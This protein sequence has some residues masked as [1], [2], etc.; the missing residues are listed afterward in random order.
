MS[1]IKYT[2][3]V[4]D[5]KYFRE[6][7]ALSDE[8]ILPQEQIDGND[9][10]EEIEKKQGI[11]IA[12]KV[13]LYRRLK[14]MSEGIQHPWFKD[15]EERLLR[16]IR[17]VE[18]TKIWEAL[19]KKDDGQ[20]MK[21]YAQHEGIKSLFTMFSNINQLLAGLKIEI[22]ELS[23]GRPGDDSH[24]IDSLTGDSSNGS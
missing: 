21:L 23:A 12:K 20:I 14:A 10:P 13:L 7:F 16:K 4:F 2:E 15:L 24:S 5:C 6:L 19:E 1:E 22:D 17:I 18:A 8:N 9:T 11:Q 3:A